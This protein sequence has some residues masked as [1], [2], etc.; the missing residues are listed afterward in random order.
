ML[1][2]CHFFLGWASALSRQS[3]EKK[4]YENGRKWFLVA[5]FFPPHHSLLAP[6]VRQLEITFLCVL[7]LLLLCG[8]EKNNVEMIKCRYATRG[9]SK[10]ISWKSELSWE[11]WKSKKNHPLFWLMVGCQLREFLYIFDTVSRYFFS[12]LVRC[13]R[14]MDGWLSSLRSSVCSIFG[15]CVHTVNNK[16]M[17]SI[18][19]R[20]LDCCVLR[21][22][23]RVCEFR[24]IL[25]YLALLR[26]SRALL[27]DEMMFSSSSSRPSWAAKLSVCETRE[28]EWCW[29]DN[30]ILG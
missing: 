29:S 11:R 27:R 2:F 18:E 24:E 21:W 16:V 10:E 7:L 8:G 15:V 5:S 17:A 26:Q 20:M 30:G 19:N 13:V 1:F 6:F 12:S 9:S 23:E 4:N 25:T 14:W 3:R 22:G 28:D